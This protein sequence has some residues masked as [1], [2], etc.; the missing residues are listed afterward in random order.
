MWDVE[1]LCNLNPDE[2]NIHVHVTLESGV[3]QSPHITKPSL[4]TQVM[5]SAALVTLPPI[6]AS[7]E[8]RRLQ[9][10]SSLHEML[11]LV[12]TKLQD[13]APPEHFIPESNVHNNRFNAA[14]RAEPLNI[15]PPFVVF[16]ASEPR[17][18]LIKILRL[19]N[20]NA[21][22]SAIFRHYKDV[23]VRT[24]GSSS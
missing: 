2:S 22:R 21:G 5:A 6:A 17:R 7:G 4:S 23:T 18:G 13:G 11:S 12:A 20:T 15:I 19:K 9:N 3:R 24:F 16:K 1:V 14:P 8:S 10:Q